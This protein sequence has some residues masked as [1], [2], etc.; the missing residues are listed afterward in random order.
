MLRPG[1]RGACA[2]LNAALRGAFFGLSSLAPLGACAPTQGYIEIAWAVID[3]GGTPLYPDGELQNTCDF[4]GL[5]KPEPIGETEGVP[6]EVPQEV[7]AILRVELTICD[8]TCEGGCDDPTCQIVDP[9]SFA[10]N[11]ARA[12]MTVPS[13]ADNDKYRFET[14][15]VAELKGDQSCTCR[16]TSACALL[17]GP[18]ER[19]VQGGLVTD[20][21][22]Y[23]VVLAL[24]EPRSAT[25]DLTECCELPPSCT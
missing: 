20:L 18:R 23:Q 11:S 9:K 4:T 21:Q 5:F 2:R 10:C 15:I 14:H 1:P 12:Q 22:V 6:Q 16:L 25:I 3:E 19:Q 17:P 13:S 7:P 8:P 24:D